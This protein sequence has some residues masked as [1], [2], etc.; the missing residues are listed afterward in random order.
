MYAGNSLRAAAVVW[1]LAFPAI[2]LAQHATDDPLAAADDA[3][4]LTL[5]LESVGLYGPGGVRGFSP[6]TAGN[7]RINGF[8]F[9]QQGSLSNRVVEGSTIRVG[10]AE[11]GYPFPS[12][13]G[14]V[15]YDLRHAGDG[16]PT[17]SVVLSDGPYQSRGG[18]VDGNLPIIG[19]TLQLPIGA[20]FQLSTGNSQGNDGY[21]SKYTSFGAIPQWTPTENITLRAFIDYQS[22]TSQRTLPNVFPDGDVIPPLLEHYVGQDWA[23]GHLWTENYGAMLTA[24]LNKHWTLSAS[25]FRSVVDTPVSFS[26]LYFNTTRTGLSDHQV[27]S[28]PDQT[29]ESS[30]GDLRL[31]GRF[32]AGS[33][34]HEV[35]FEA[36]GRDTLAL[37]GGSDDVDVGPAYIYQGRQVPEP[38]FTY[39]PL[40][41]D[42]AELWSIGTAYRAQ[43]QAHADFTVGV[44]RESYDKTVVTPGIPEGRL[45]DRPLR[46]YTTGAI[47]LAKPLT[48][49]AS[50]TQGL[51]ESGTAP[52]NAQN[53]GAVLAAARTQQEDTGFRYQLTDK[54]K[55]IVGG[56][57]IEKPYY[58]IDLDNVDRQLGTQRARGFEFSLSG[59]VTQGMNVNFGL[60]DGKVAIIGSNLQADGVGPV[61]FGQPRLLYLFDADYHFQRWPAFSSDL[62][63]FRFGAVPASVDN[64][65][66][67]PAQVLV[68][69]G[70]RYRF[71]LFNHPATLRLAYQ[72]LNNN[73]FWSTSL[74]PGFYQFPGSVVIGYLTADL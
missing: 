70:G 20:G 19:T 63:L 51:E 58:N 47:Q 22:L 73:N 12:P 15:D 67:N 37:Y 38:N 41:H 2:C 1:L 66:Y 53:R 61:A 68:N 7:V 32:I 9:D 31:A 52:S 62:V 10:I 69:L 14:I 18:S 6:Q 3:F 4:G 40:T 74:S 64:T 44:Q 26:D 8:Y 21:T 25:G 72:D 49:Y 29:T 24:R 48:M 55:L 34:R 5:G 56:F 71:K 60:L 42:R 30:S 50:Y 28:Y 23:Q 43:W 33:W 16:T 46:G 36:H 59:Q 17:A 54:L 45:T 27:V 35:I 11:I 57:E 65:L 39:G 13:T